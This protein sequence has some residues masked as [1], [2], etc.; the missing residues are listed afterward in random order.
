MEGSE[1]FYA[2]NGWVSVYLNLSFGAGACCLYVEIELPGSCAMQLRDPSLSWTSKRFFGWYIYYHLNW[3]R[4]I[5]RGTTLQAGVSIA[6]ATLDYILENI[7][8]RTLFATHYHELGQMLGYNPKRAGGEVIKG[9]SGITFWCTDV[10][11]AVSSIS[12]S[13]RACLWC[14]DRTA[15]FLILTSYDLV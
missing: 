2:W 15:L 14:Q 1:H 4:R 9:R 10:D 7:K 13:K 5:G 3:C 6:Y 8:C 12:L 11:E